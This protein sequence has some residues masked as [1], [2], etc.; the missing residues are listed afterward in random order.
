MTHKKSN[1]AL[2]KGL[3]VGLLF[4]SPVFAAETPR[5]T[6]C[7]AEVKQP[8]RVEVASTPAQRQRGLMQRAALA[9][10]AGMLFRFDPPAP[11]GQ[12]F[13]M[14][15]TLIPLDIAFLDED[16]RI[17]ALRTMTPCES[18]NPRLCR[19]Y[20]AGTEYSAALEVN[21]GFFHQH[22]VEVG[23]RIRSASGGGCESK[24]SP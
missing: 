19:V 12:G 22:G 18:D 5:E 9:P 3:V 21:A 11:A 6:L 2:W 23:D 15:R 14:Y 16:G 24:P 17:L 20:Q 8:V 10:D 7:V 4:C 1:K 13:Y